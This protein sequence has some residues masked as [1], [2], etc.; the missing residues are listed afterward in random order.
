MARECDKYEAFFVF[1]EEEEF[2]NH[3]ESCESCQKEHQKML[4]ISS[5]VKE[6]KFSYLKNERKKAVAKLT[7]TMFLL[8]FCTGFIT[9]VFYDREYKNLAIAQ[10]SNVA[11]LGLPVDEYG[12]LALK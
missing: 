12:L 5:L 9:V 6:V 4:K 1:A 11:Q 2:K 10:E 3:I 8:L 7:A